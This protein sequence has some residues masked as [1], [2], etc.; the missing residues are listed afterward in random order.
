MAYHVWLYCLQ[1]LIPN[2][3]ISFSSSGKENTHD[4]D[5]SS[6]YAIIEKFIEMV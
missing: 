3:I 2:N 4:N 6:K 5:D 1:E